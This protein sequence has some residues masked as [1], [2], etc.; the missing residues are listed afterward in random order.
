M[1]WMRLMG[2]AAMVLGLFATGRAARAELLEYKRGGVVQLP[3]RVDGDQ[4][5][6]LAPDGPR[7]FRREDFRRIVPGYWPPDEWPARREAALVGDA[8]TAFAA[9]WWALENGLVDEATHAIRAAHAVDPSHQPAARLVA[10]LDRLGDALPDPELYA[11]LTRDFAS[12]SEA[13]GAHILLLHQHEASEAAGRIDDLEEVVAAYY[14]L[15]EALG[16]S[17]APPEERLVVLWYRDPAAFS[18][19]VRREAGVGLAQT[20]GYYSPARGIVATLDPRGWASEGDLDPEDSDAS[21]RALLLD[22]RNRAM[23]LGTAAHELTHLL[24]ARSGVVPGESEFPLWLQEGLATQFEVVRGGRWAGFGRV[25]AIRLEALRAGSAPRLA[26]LLADEGFGHGQRPEPYAAAWAWVYFLR[27]T[28]PAELLALI[29]SHRAA[30]YSLRIEPAGPA[31]D[32]RDETE[33]RRFIALLRVPEDVFGVRHE[34]RPRL[35]PVDMNSSPDRINRAG[36][37]DGA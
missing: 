24:L 14:L 36:C 8:S 10:L 21:R 23:D 34:E 32:R 6:L 37:E 17:P 18:S 2:R 11:P 7:G 9:A 5:V 15:F 1:A 29:D 12:F 26:E 4:V 31:F 30:A 28:R 27:K 33:W 25:N 35:S 19:F 13:R 20:T 22:L 16:L 3:C